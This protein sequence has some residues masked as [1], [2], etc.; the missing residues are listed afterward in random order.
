MR[1][2]AAI[3]DCQRPHG[4]RDR[5]SVDAREGY[6]MLRRTAIGAVVALLLAGTV[7]AQGQRKDFQVF[8]DIAQEVLTYPRFTVFDDVAGSV[9]Q[10]VVTLRGKVTMPYKV[11][12]LERRV[13]RVA[14]VRQVR[15][16]IHV[17]PVSFFDDD[18]RYQIARAI[19]RNPGFWQYAA[20]ANP[21]IHIVVENGSVTLTGV[22]NSNVE[23][24]LARSL[25]SSFGAFSIRNEL[26]T[27]A[28]M[29]ALLEK[30]D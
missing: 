30:L 1:F 14:G 8:K 12:E 11:K 16:E 5:P 18:L 22:V 13:A 4:N 3:I 15:N 24:M 27:D 20:M 21:P 25:A 26:K 2:A 6:P 19:Y 10:G 28:E 29:Q 7:L 9:D 23:R 17:L